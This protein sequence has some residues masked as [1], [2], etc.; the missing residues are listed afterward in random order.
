MATERRTEKPMK[1]GEALTLRAD[2][3]TRIEQLRGRLR[4]S[5]LVQEGEKPPEDPD[6]ML[7]EFA[8]LA[9]QLEDL[10]RRI[11]RTN[12]DTRLSQGQTL[13]EALARRDS[14]ALRHGVLRQVADT[15]AERQQRYS[16]AEI[17]TLPTVDVAALRQQTDDLARERRELDATI[18]EANW[19]TDLAE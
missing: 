18:Q 12:I 16:R 3:Q 13:T 7:R 19:L 6:T 8:G 9:D 11:N 14:L 4:A 2:I 10:V 1:L 5:A 17:R 15:A